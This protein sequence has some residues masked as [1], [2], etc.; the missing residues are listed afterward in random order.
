M[1][2]DLPE[3]ST[4]RYGLAA[5]YAQLERTDDARALIAPELATGFGAFV[6]TPQW[7]LDLYCL[8][9]C[10]IALD[11]PRASHQIYDIVEPNADIY[12][13]NAVVSYDMFHLLLAGLATTFGDLDRADAHFADAL[14]AH[15]RMGAAHSLAKTQAA[16]ADMLV[17]RG[18]EADIVQARELA[19]R[20]LA[21]AERGGYGWVERDATAVL[22]R[23]D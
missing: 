4:Y 2:A 12:A 22:A 1:Q 19:T 3:F 20:A 10:V 17:R 11:D 13:A 21:A 8:G 16:W 15:E 6:L 14:L 18:A 23:L 9:E 5:A 7:A